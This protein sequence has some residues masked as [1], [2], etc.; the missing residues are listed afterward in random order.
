MTSAN[1]I[2]VRPLSGAMGAEVSGVDL[3]RPLDNETAEAIH[4]AF[5][6]HIAIFIPVKDLPAERMEAFVARFGEPMA[7]PYLKPVPGSAFVHELRKTPEEEINFGNVWHQDFTNLERPSLANAL[8]SRVVPSHGGDTLFTNMYA[9]FEGLSPGMQALI[10]G[11]KAVHG[12]SEVYKRDIRAQEARKDVTKRDEGHAKYTS[13]AIE[14][15]FAHPVVRTHPET[16]RK[17]L[18]VNPGFT[19]RFEN[20]TEAESTPLLDFLYRHA[21]RP[22]YTYRH[23]W[24]AD[25][26]GIWDNR[27]SMHYAINDYTGQLRVMHRMV[28]LESEPPA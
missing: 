7:H 9:A 11:L 3:T 12:F 8:Y 20:M 5:L 1:G 22:E 4:Q 13:E 6:D 18:Y 21:I 2:E 10:E 27:A 23:S 15:T 16:G 28:V 24:R 19:L 25:V 14:K 26:L 17:A